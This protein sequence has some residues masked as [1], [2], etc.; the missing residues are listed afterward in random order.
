MTTTPDSPSPVDGV[1]EPPDGSAPGQAP[2][3]LGYRPELD[4]LRAVAVVLVFIAHIGFVWPSIN[5]KVLPGSFQGVDLFF[6]LSGFL[7]TSLL[8]EERERTGGFSFRGFYRRRALRLL[9][10]LLFILV[11]NLAYQAQQRLP[12]W[13]TFKAYFFIVFYISNWATVI[14]NPFILTFTWGHMWSLAVE[15]QYYV[16]FFPLLI[17]LLRRARSLRTVAWVLSGGI[18][19]T[20]LWRFVAT[21]RSAPTDFTL[22]YVRT[23]VRADALLLGPLVA[24]LVHLGHRITPKVRLLA[25]PAL[26][27]LVWTL[28]YA[29]VDDR[30]L[31]EWAIG[32]ID[33]A[34]TIVMVAVLG[35]GHVFARALRLRPVVW[36]GKISYG[37]YL[38]HLPVFVLL[39]RHVRFRHLPNWLPFVLAMFV[40][41]ACATFSYYVV[42]RPFLRRKRPRGSTDPAPPPTP[43]PAPVSDP[44]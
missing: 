41:F 39:Y 21:S 43:V 28:C 15:E 3:R 12:L 22:L 1:T 14:G 18:V 37:L 10:A 29:R 4:G 23:D 34:W 32:P 44:A 38:W 31:Y 13:P 27:Y 33:I 17:V 40:T 9:P 6:V 36:I 2:F 25:I 7:L 5:E 42:E 8:L 16:I 11:V 24:V 26:A 19:V 20:W 35:G 30:W